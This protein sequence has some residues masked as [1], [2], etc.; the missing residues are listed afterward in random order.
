MKRFR[1]TVNGQPFEVTVE[2]TA[3]PGAAQQP[4]RLP[5][6]PQPPGFTPQVVPPPQAAP[7]PAAPPG[8]GAAGQAPGAVTAPLPGLVVAVKVEVGQAVAAGQVLMVLEAMKM[9]NDITAPAAGV[10][11]EI[12]V[13]PGTTV[14][15]GQALA[16]I[17]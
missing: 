2:E 8:R 12:L 7:A 4:V 13:E 16:V 6:P 5:A 11:K 14:A 3:G 1:V 15:G 17:G 10:V 9:E